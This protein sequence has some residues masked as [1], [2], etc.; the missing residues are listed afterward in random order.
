LVEL[1][2][3]F[4]AAS[5][6]AR[7]IASVSATVAQRRRGGVRVQ[8]LHIGRIRAC[9]AQRIAIAAGASPSSGGAVMWC[10]SPLMPK[11]TSSA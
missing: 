4:F 2:A 3:I 8:V 9:I 10:A 6:K 11:P 5:P 1:T 7:L